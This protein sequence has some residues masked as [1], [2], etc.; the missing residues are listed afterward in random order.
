MSTTSP[1]REFDGVV[2]VPHRQR[3]YTAIC[4]CFR[5]FTLDGSDGREQYQSSKPPRSHRSP[6][7]RS[8]AL[9]GPH[10]YVQPRQSVTGIRSL[11]I[12]P[13][14]GSGMTPRDKSVERRDAST[15][16]HEEVDPR[17][18]HHEFIQKRLSSTSTYTSNAY[19]T[20][21]GF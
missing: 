17:Q 13:L 14:Q 8:L 11:P 21:K 12:A 9:A 15:K 16:S 6:T 20:G 18:R 1:A 3:Y 10:A 7:R 4:D 5:T 2:A 19:S